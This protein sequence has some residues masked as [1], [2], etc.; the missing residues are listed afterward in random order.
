[1]TVPKFCANCGAPL[2]PN[3]KFCSH[4]GARVAVA[5]ADQPAPAQPTPVAAQPAQPTQPTPAAAQPA[6]AQP[7]PAATQPAQP[8]QPTPAAAQPAQPTQPTPAAAQPAQPTQP[9]PAATRPAPAATSVQ[10]AAHAAQFFQ[11]IRH[12]E[13]GAVVTV[14]LGLGWFVAG[15]S[16]H[17]V[18]TGVST[19]INTIA[20]DAGV[21][22]PDIDLT[23]MTAGLAPLGVLMMIIAAALAVVGVLAWVRPHWVDATGLA[24][25][26]V[27]AGAVG[28]VLFGGI[29]VQLSHTTLPNSSYTIGQLLKAA[30]SGTDWLQSALGSGLSKYTTLMQNVLADFRL[31]Q[32]L[33]LIVALIGAAFGGLL[34][35]AKV[36]ASL[37]AA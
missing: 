9:T 29:K 21:A 20:F 14:L 4:C 11:V 18:A 2:T 13:V 6:A 26:N 30:Q 22:T 28:L 5:P 1:M 36:Q 33:L 25:A 27:G 23:R 34:L 10:P 19:I 24:A 16:L 37:A 8:T 3:A 35:Y 32:S 15:S 12:P 7:T 17:K 31:A